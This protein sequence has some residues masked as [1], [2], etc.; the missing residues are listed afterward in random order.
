[1]NPDGIRPNRIQPDLNERW[2]LA[3]IRECPEILG[4]G[5]LVL[6]E[7]RTRSASGRLELVLHDPDTNYQ[8]DVALQAGATDDRHFLR[9]VELWAAERKQTPRRCHYAVLIAEDVGSR[10]LRIAGLLIPSI[11]LVIL[12]MEAFRPG[13]ATSLRFT[14]LQPS[15]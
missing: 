1:V 9:T 4:L 12:R 8:Y 13:D 15:T 11:P 5:D 3:C 14:K 6:D 10:F 7:V 2:L